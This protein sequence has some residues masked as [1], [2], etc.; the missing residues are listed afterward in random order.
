MLLAMSHLAEMILSVID[1]DGGRMLL[2]S[3]RV[4]LHQIGAPC[5]IFDFHAGVNELVAKGRI[6]VKGIEGVGRVATVLPQTKEGKA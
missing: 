2:A 4:K 3:V 6:A 1:L 5:S